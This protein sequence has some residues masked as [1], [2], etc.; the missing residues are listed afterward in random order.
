MTNLD[1]FFLTMSIIVGFGF[2]AAA[3]GYYFIARDEGWFEKRR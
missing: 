3:I 2:V 1:L